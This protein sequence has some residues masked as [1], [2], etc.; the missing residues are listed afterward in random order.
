MLILHPSSDIA[1]AA[2][3][4]SST[5]AEE[6]GGG[7]LGETSSVKYTRARLSF[8]LFTQ[9]HNVENFLFVCF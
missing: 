9:L 2:H 3:K 4:C 1:K 6:G 5:T 8:A 7:A